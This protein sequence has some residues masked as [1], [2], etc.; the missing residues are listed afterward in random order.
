MK[1]IIIELRERINEWEIERMNEEINDWEIERL[2][3]WESDVRTDNLAALRGGYR[4]YRS[5][6]PYNNRIS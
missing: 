6:F 3:E 1:N 2:N 4:L 5:Y